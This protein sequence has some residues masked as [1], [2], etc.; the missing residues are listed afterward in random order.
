MVQALAIL[1]L[2]GAAVAI[3]GIMLGRSADEIANITALGE[4]WTGWVL[5]AAATSL[6]EF[7]TD[8]SAVKL[9]AANLAAGDLFG[10]SLTNMAIL[11]VMALIPFAAE[12]D[13]GEAP[14]SLFGA[15]LAIVLT[16]LGATFTL[17]HGDL[18]IAGWRPESIILVLIWIVGTRMLYSA[19]S[20]GG[21]NTPAAIAAKD[22]P[23]DRPSLRRPL[24]VFAAGSAIIFL[25]APSFANSAR[26][27][28]SLSGLGDSFV[29]T[30][31]LGFST[32]LPEFVTSITVCRLGAF[33]LAVANLYGSC[34]FNMVVFFLMDLASPVPIFSTLDPVLALSG[35]LAVALMLLGLAAV[36]YRRRTMF[37]PNVGGGVL[38]AMYGFAIW[39]IYLYR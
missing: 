25:I 27:F 39:V 10:S 35:F 36:A 33:D 31:L 19:Q 24:I 7:V 8:V 30:W 17:I 38:L 21:A 2:T 6:P 1:I 23:A 34:A 11:A 13:P 5:L 9:R 22:P 18:T 29:G 12:A 20:N 15:W 14:S 32:A 26:Q 37:A 28:A 3:A 4:M 16:A